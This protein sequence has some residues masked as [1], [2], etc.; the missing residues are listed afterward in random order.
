MNP[1]AKAL[2]GQPVG[3][4]RTPV[5]RPWLGLGPDSGGAIGLT[6]CLLVL[7]VSPR[8]LFQITHRGGYDGWEL[9][10]GLQG[11]CVLMSMGICVLVFG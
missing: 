3:R 4:R 2:V 10:D 1:A 9:Y 8:V 5:A 6:L 11:G 7:V